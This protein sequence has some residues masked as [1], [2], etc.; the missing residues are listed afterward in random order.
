MKIEQAFLREVQRRGWTIEAVDTA[1]CIARCS[2]CALRVKLTPDGHIP[3][4][5]A[6]AYQ[7]DV[8]LRSNEDGRVALRERRQELGLIITDV[9]HIAGLT[10]DHL[11]KAEMP[12]PSRVVNVDTFTIWANA[13]GFDVV[14]RRKEL[15]PVT[16][17]AIID[18]RLMAAARQRRFR[19]ARDGR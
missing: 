18:T 6:T 12:N 17:R 5:T 16:L 7:S 15:P 11:A 9:E 19:A 3:S 10:P 13:L 2:D 4:K 14:L 8:V 1:S